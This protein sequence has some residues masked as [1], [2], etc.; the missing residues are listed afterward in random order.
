MKE[1]NEVQKRIKHLENLRAIHEDTIR[2][3]EEILARF[4]PLNRP[5][6]RVSELELERE[7]LRKVEEELAALQKQKPEEP[8][9]PATEDGCPI[10]IGIGIIG[11]AV[12]IIVVLAILL[13]KDE[14]VTSAPTPTLGP[15]AEG[16]REKDEAVMVYV[17]AGEFIINI[18]GNQHPVYVD[19]F[20]IDKYEVTNEWFARF[21]EDQDYKTL[22]EGY[23]QGKACIY[24]F[25]DKGWLWDWQPIPGANWQDPDG[26]DRPFAPE[27]AEIMDHPVVQVCWSDARAYCRWAGA[28][29]PK[30]EEWMKAAGWD[31]EEKRQRRYPWGDE[32]TSPRLNYCGEGC[33]CPWGGR[34]NRGL[35]WNDGYPRTAP[36]GSY[37][38]GVSFY[39]GAFDMVGNVWEFT[40]DRFA[41]G[42][43]WVSQLVSCTV[44]SR[45]ELLGDVDEPPCSEDA[46]GFR[47]AWSP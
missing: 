5:L 7:A 19:G 21:V 1:T 4:G 15:G 37:P 42:G 31:P 23:N 28:R 22:P 24:T 20:W 32:I 35:E 26:P 10:L 36:V 46:T 40:E 17:P 16:F 12:I 34:D 9:R 43:S 27:L 38:D 29:L 11:I 39:Y 3:L 45:F 47:C 25:T 30:S 44:T 13:K 18:D 8:S 14:A 2:Q 33:G 41:Y 6:H